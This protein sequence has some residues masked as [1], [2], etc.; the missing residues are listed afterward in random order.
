MWSLIILWLEDAKRV[1]LIYFIYLQERVWMR[2]DRRHATRKWLKNHLTQI[3][4]FNSNSPPPLFH[5]SVM[6]GPAVQHFLFLPTLFNSVFR[7]KWNF[8]QLVM[9][10]KW[11]HHITM[12]PKTLLTWSVKGKIYLLRFCIKYVKFIKC[13]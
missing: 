2:H 3:L 11:L 12:L 10:S 5:S 9:L 4:M 13:L 8:Y 6:M 7:V 1:C